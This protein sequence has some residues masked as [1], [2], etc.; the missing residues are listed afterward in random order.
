MKRRRP[1]RKPRARL[2]CDLGRHPTVP[3]RPP[4]PNFSRRGLTPLRARPCARHR[5]RQPWPYPAPAPAR[6]L[7]R[8][9][10]DQPPPVVVSISSRTTRTRTRTRTSRRPIDDVRGQPIQSQRV[11]PLQARPLLPAPSPPPPQGQVAPALLRLY[12]SRHARCP[13][14]GQ[15]PTHRA[16]RDRPPRRADVSRR[17]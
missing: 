5:P 14:Q 11:A 1:R 6:S 4:R 13:R 10:R 3:R 15:G 16:R 8:L 9:C 7:A 12:R 2:P 17:A